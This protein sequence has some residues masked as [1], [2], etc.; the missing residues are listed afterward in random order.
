MDK[1]F[2][3]CLRCGYVTPFDVD[4]RPKCAKCGCMTG[5]VDESGRT[6]NFRVGAPRTSPYL[7]QPQRRDGEND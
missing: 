6:Q 3:E 4:K 1:K 2:F 7:R 5:L